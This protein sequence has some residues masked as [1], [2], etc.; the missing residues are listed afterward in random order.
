VQ[1]EE[2]MAE[3]RENERK[4]HRLFFSP[5]VRMFDIITS[6]LLF[7][8]FVCFSISFITRFSLQLNKMSLHF[9]FVTHL[10]VVGHP[11]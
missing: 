2:R 6:V 8:L 5:W 10:P 3:G 1:K 4:G 9:I 11:G 7:C